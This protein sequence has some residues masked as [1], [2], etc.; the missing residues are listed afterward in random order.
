MG[1]FNLGMLSTS[2]LLDFQMEMLKGQLDIQ[3]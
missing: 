2:R 3:L 1:D